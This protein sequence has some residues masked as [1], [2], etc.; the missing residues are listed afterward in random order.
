[1]LIPNGQFETEQQE[2]QSPPKEMEPAEMAHSSTSI[3]PQN[4][5]NPYNTQNTS[6]QQ[7]T[8]NPYCMSLE[9]E[10]RTLLSLSRSNFTGNITN[11]P[12]KKV[13]MVES[14]SDEDCRRIRE[15]VQANP[16]KSILELTQMLYKELN[17]GNSEDPLLQRTIRHYV[18]IFY[19]QR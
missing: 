1:M 12:S 17:R 6:K 5:R 8:S 3:L 10:A 9:D 18:H 14:L 15:C 11:P 2:N 4:T 13:E 7:N 19:Q 16:K